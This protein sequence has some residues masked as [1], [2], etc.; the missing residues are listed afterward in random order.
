MKR[1][2]AI[3]NIRNVFIC[4]K[5]DKKFK[6]GDTVLELE[7]DTF[8]RVSHLE[9]TN[10][11]NKFITSKH[12]Y[13]E[14]FVDPNDI[15][16]LQKFPYKGH[17]RVLTDIYSDEKLDQFRTK[18]IE[19]KCVDI[20]NPEFIWYETSCSCNDEDHKVSIQLSYDPDFLDL[21]LYMKCRMFDWEAYKYDY[22]PN[23]KNWV[24]YAKML[25]NLSRRFLWRLKKCFR[26][27]FCGSMELDGICSLKGQDHIL[28]LYQA[29][30]TGSDLLG[31]NRELHINTPEDKK[32]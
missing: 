14:Y 30:V 5:D 12:S 1:K 26:I 28:E 17:K 2:V 7:D 23:D 15:D 19:I 20:T 29:L 31:Y 9:L 32:L 27:F 10:N 18:S 22:E 16:S 4:L 8:E 11:F 3:L 6:F 25:R 21:T 13:S 24:I